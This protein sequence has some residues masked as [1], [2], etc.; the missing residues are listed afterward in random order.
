[1]NCYSIIPYDYQLLSYSI[2]QVLNHSLIGTKKG[3]H[4]TDLNFVTINNEF[5]GY[6]KIQN[7]WAAF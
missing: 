6:L 5:S 7:A 1:M 3:L 4:K 2:I